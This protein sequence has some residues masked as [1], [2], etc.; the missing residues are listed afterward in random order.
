MDKKQIET[1]EQCLMVWHLFLKKKTKNSSCCF[2][3]KGLKGPE[4]EPGVQWG[5]KS[6]PTRQ[7]MVRWREM[8]KCKRGLGVLMKWM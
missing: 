8:G 3:G 4:G 1:W 6:V 2:M 5:D 7:E